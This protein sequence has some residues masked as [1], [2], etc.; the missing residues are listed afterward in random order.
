MKSHL[1][2]MVLVGLVL[3]TCGCGESNNTRSSSYHDLP[4]Y[5][6][7]QNIEA[8]SCLMAILE[9]FVNGSGSGSNS[10]FTNP[11]GWQE[12]GMYGSYGYYEPWMR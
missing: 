2:Y 5:Q 7:W 6:E 3:L 8:F 10:Y 9:S 11:Y 12:G 1:T 4:T